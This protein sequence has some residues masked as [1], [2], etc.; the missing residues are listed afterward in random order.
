MD[1]EI[2]NTNNLGFSNDKNEYFEFSEL[3]NN[4]EEY[5]EIEIED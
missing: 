4:D 1:I 2:I 3:S 5:I